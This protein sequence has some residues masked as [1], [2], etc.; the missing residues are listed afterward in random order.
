MINMAYSATILLRN[1]VI[2][3]EVS[4]FE[5]WNILII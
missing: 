4:Q 5:S 1:I 2:L 3:L